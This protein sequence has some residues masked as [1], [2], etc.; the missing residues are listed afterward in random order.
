MARLLKLTLFVVMIVKSMCGI[1]CDILMLMG[2][3]ELKGSEKQLAKHD[4]TNKAIDKFRLL[5]KV[6]SKLLLNQSNTSVI[7][8]KFQ[9]LIELAFHQNIIYLLP[10]PA[11]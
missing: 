10:N 2:N 11:K 7:P 3:L 8:N 9:F 1:L 6:Q 5:L 4:S